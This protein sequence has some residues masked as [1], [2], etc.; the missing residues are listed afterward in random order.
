M[1]TSDKISAS[2]RRAVVTGGGNGI[3]A[4]ACTALAASGIEI[5]VADLDGAAAERVARAV[6]DVSGGRATY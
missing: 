6:F 4:A 3:G 2:E 5:V 1:M